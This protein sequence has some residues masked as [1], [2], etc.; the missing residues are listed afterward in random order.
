MGVFGKNGGGLFGSLLGIGLAFM[1]AGASLAVFAQYAAIGFTIG[2]LLAPPEFDD[3]PEEFLA[4]EVKEGATIPLVVGRQ[5]VRGVI[6]YFAETHVKSEKSGDFQK[7]YWAPMQIAVCICEKY[8]VDDPY[9]SLYLPGFSEGGVLAGYHT[10]LTSSLHDTHIGVQAY[11]ND[12]EPWTVFNYFTIKVGD[13]FNTFVADFAGDVSA[14]IE[15]IEA[16]EQD[17]YHSSENFETAYSFDLVTK[18]WPQ[19]S[20]GGNSIYQFD[21]FEA[22]QLS[23]IFPGHVDGILYGE[24]CGLDRVSDAGIGLQAASGE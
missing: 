11:E 23:G 24:F 22:E 15:A 9:G 12:G 5:R 8:P 19:V 6:T 14:L 17:E 16:Y 3:E 1:T 7:N 4:P 20:W 10:N 2:N 18:G 13:S 21:V